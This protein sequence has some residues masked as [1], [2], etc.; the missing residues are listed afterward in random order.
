MREQKTKA[1]IKKKTNY[2][3][4]ATPAPHPQLDMNQPLPSTYHIPP[5]F[6]I[7]ISLMGT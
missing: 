2:E 7:T 6:I 1:Q 3:I 4:T 5:S